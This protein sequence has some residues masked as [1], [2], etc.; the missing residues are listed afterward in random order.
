[1]Q[2]ELTV[3]Q[4][5]LSKEHTYLPQASF[6]HEEP[7]PFRRAIN[8]YEYPNDSLIVLD[9]VINFLKV[10]TDQMPEIFVD[11]TS[12][13]TKYAIGI[14]E[15]AGLTQIELAILARGCFVHDIIKGKWEK[16]DSTLVDLE[17]RVT[18]EQYAKIIKLHP[19]RGKLLIWDAAKKL[20]VVDHPVVQQI[21]RITE[22]HHFFY[23]GKGYPLCIK[24]SDFLTRIVSIADSFDA[25]TTRPYN[26][27]KF[28]NLQAAHNEVTQCMGTQFDPALR[29]PFDQWF[30]DNYVELDRGLEP[31]RQ[32]YSLRAIEVGA[33]Q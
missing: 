10:H 13:V 15:K 3:Y 32:K 1:M 26:K 21:M 20:N 28:C 9:Q 25:M 17:W 33:A 4:A 5:P 7:S 2:T 16:A 23:N 12:R 30:F 11:H 22:G 14:G 6:R 27:E 31:L 18:K 24:E 8:L 29:V 19:M